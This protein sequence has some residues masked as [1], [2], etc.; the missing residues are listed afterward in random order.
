MKSSRQNRG[1]ALLIVLVIIALLSTLLTEL[2]FS[3]LVDLRLTE[4]FRDTTRAYYL[5]KGGVN[6]GRMIIQEDRNGYD[7]LDEPWSQGVVNYPVGEGAITVRITD[8]NGKLGINAMVNRDTPS[9]LMIDRFYRLMLALEIDKWGDPAELTAALIDW[10]DEGESPYPMILTEGLDIPVAG[11]EATYYQSL[12]QPYLV[13]NGRVET[14]EELA[15]IKGFTP[16]ILRRVLPHVALH[17]EVKVNINTA[18]STVLMSLDPEI[19]EDVADI[20]IGYRKEAP[21]KRLEQ[22]EEV[23]PE[24]AYIALKTLGNLEQLDLRSNF[25]QIEADA[26]VNDGRRRLVAQVNKKNNKLTFFKVD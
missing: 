14:L 3:T 5:A 24:A 10:I 21:I 18:S 19:D 16:E 2:A 1:M 17:E 15:L 4:T 13:K 8:Q 6:A 11:A 25:Y 20:L 9:A 26:V 23:L 7:S 22:L 12:T